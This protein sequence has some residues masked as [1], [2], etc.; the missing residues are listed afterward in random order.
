MYDRTRWH[1]GQTPHG[2]PPA[3]RQTAAS[4][5]RP[6]APR[7]RGSERAVPLLGQPRALGIP[8]ALGLCAV[9]RNADTTLHKESSQPHLLLFSPTGGGVSV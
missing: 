1:D 7:Q 4:A 2:W 5:R 9:S 3:P 8:T 6:V